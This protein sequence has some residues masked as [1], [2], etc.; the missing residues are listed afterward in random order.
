LQRSVDSSALQIVDD[1]K[2]AD[3]D[4]N[5]QN[6]EHLNFLIDNKIKSGVPYIE[7]AANALPLLF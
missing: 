4:K 1:T 7:P 3:T 6:K 2:E 5:K